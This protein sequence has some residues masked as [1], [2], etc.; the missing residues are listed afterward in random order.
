MLDLFKNDMYLEAPNLSPFFCRLTTV[1][2]VF[3]SSLGHSAPLRRSPFA[4]GRF[5]LVYFYYWQTHC[6][7]GAWRRRE[8]GNFSSEPL[9]R[10]NSVIRGEECRPYEECPEKNLA[11]SLKSLSASKF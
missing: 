4:G 7:G 9:N 1:S 3:L 10:R 8:V 5:F 6:G 11:F 2:A